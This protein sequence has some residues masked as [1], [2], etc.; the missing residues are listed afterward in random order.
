MSKADLTTVDGFSLVLKNYEKSIAQLLQSKY[1]ISAEEF[2]VTCVNAV[3]KSPKL[4]QCDPR[5]LFGAILLSAECGLKPNT[6]EQHAFIIPYKGQAQFQVGYKGLVEMMY[7]NP[8]V[9][10]IYAE[11]VYE[12]DTF[13]YWYGLKPDL[14]HKPFRDGDRGSLI[15]VYAV[16]KLKDAEPIFTVVEKSE[17]NKIKSLSPS[18]NS[19]NSPYTNGTDVHNYMEIKSAI[20]KISKLIPKAS[21]TELSKAIEYDSRFEGGA[22]VTAPILSSSNE[23]AEANIIDSKPST[24]SL[25]S[26]FDEVLEETQPTENSIIHNEGFEINQS[27]DFEEM[28]NLTTTE[29]VEQKTVEENVETQDIKTDNNSLF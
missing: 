15:C 24:N 25:E 8:R 10:T 22:K 23:I 14:I 4:L 1:G 12:N 29:K 19:N 17:L 27:I 18:T 2:Y 7:R 21:I 20:K 11:A 16:C 26:S 13:E 28:Q 6:P 3:K 9:Q 5:S